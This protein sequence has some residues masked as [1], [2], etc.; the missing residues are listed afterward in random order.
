MTGLTNI[1]KVSLPR[2]KELA[3]F[4]SQKAVALQE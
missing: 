1:P 3:A 4:K 2:Q